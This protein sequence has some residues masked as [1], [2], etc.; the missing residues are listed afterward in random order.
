[1]NKDSIAAYAFKNADEAIAYFE[2][3]IAA[4]KVMGKLSHEE[5]IVILKT[6]ATPVTVEDLVDLIQNQRVLALRH[7][8]ES[9]DAT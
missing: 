9:N 1:M 8:Q 2:R 7:K 6:I 5:K 4:E 3:C